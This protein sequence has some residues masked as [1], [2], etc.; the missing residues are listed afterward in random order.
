MMKT[1]E[2]DRRVFLKHAGLAALSLPLVDLGLISCAKL[3]RSESTAPSDVPWRVS[4]VA[5]GEPG[6]LLIV[7]GTIY[8]PDGR[9]PLEGINLYVYQTDATGNYSTTGGNNRLTRIHG[10]MRTNAQGRYEFQ[11]IK[12]APYPKG[13]ESAHIHAYVSGPGYPEYW[14]D[15]YLFADDPF[16]T[17]EERAKDAALGNFAAIL[18]LERQP[19]GVLRGR[20]DIRIERC[21]RNCT[22]N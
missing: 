2:S 20:R 11:T 8:A 3:A 16:I 18:K 1:G 5:A 10:L 15:S 4:T 6:D 17:N 21:S 14:I 7:S 13:R 9:T 12:P 19:D 22:G